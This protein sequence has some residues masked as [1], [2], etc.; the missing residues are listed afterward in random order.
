MNFQTQAKR[1]LKQ[2]RSSKKDPLRASTLERYGGA[3][4]NHIL[5]VLGKTKLKDVGNKAARDFVAGLALSPASVKLTLYVLMA[6]VKSAVD[7]EGNRLYPVVWNLDFIDPPAVRNQRAPDLPLPALQQALRGANGPDKALYA[8][9][10]GTGLRISEALSLVLGDAPDANFWSP[11]QG[12]I[13]IRHGKTDAATRIV[14]LH[15][16]L[17]MFLAETLD[18]DATRLFPASDDMYA[19][20]LREA[21]G[22]SD[23]HRF[24]RFRLT[25]L[26]NQ[27]VPVGLKKFWAGHAA[28]DVTE[29]YNKVGKDI[30]VRKEWAEKAGLGFDL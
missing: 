3:L 17:N 11:T 19:D 6:V 30:A 14:D 21:V 7:E 12:I 10:A 2:I 15:P 25:H 16:T 20:H 9:L 13:N 18:I 23:F 5:P 8:L 26:D 24:R 27:N 29:R 4:D 22:F 1:W 28:A